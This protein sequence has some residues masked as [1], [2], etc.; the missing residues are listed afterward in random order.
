MYTLAEQHPEYVIG[1][2]IMVGCL[3]IIW[4]VVVDNFKNNDYNDNCNRQ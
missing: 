4:K 1:D 2:F 3:S